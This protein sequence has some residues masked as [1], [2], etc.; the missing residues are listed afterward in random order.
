MH[1]ISVGGSVL[2]YEPIDRPDSSIGQGSQGDQVNLNTQGEF[3]IN[4]DD[5]PDNEMID[6]VVASSVIED[7][8]RSE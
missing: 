5:S 7:R 8:S 1:T 4:N 6:T 2:D 3:V